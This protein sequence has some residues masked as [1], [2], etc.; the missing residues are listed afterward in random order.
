VGTWVGLGGVT[1]CCVEQT[2][3]FSDIVKGKPV[4]KGWYETYPSPYV[5]TGPAKP[6]HAGDLME[7]IV[8]KKGDTYT[9]KLYDFGPSGSL[10]HQLWSQEWQVTDSG[11]DDASAEAV[12]ED[13]PIPP[14]S[15]ATLT[16][17]GTATFTDV[18][19]NSQPAT[20]LRPT[21]YTLTGGRVRVSGLNTNT[22][23]F[24]VTYEHS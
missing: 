21:A 1:G 22:D 8:S 23:G 9:F 10:I 17:F 13:P 6:V 12:T 16:E 14:D 24:S 5:L 2:G 18:F 11:L 15:Y 20:D 3:T 19:F 7:G 4:Y